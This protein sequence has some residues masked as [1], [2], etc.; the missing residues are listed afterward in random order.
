[1][2]RSV[3]WTIAAAFAALLVL[4][5]LTI[6]MQPPALSG[7][8]DFAMEPATGNSTII[9]LHLIRSDGTTLKGVIAVATGIPAVRIVG[10]GW[11]D[12]AR[13]SLRAA[14]DPSVAASFRPLLLQELRN[15][16]RLE[17]HT[18]LCSFDVYVLNSSGKRHLTPSAG[19][20]SRTYVHERDA[21]LEEA[22][23][24]S[25]ASALEAILGRPVIDE[26]GVTGWYDLEFSWGEDRPASVA[27][28]LQNRFGLLLTPTRREL[29]ALVIDRA[30]PGAAL[31]LLSQVGHLTLGAP[32]TLRNQIGKALTIH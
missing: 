9:D 29:D 4:S 30:E 17:T 23:L 7:W 16:L 12:E 28:V 19:H 10:P 1:M 26:T 27:A 20:D 31:T 21:R 15:R 6:R 22:S 3:A 25:L 8:T 5:T 11:L 18:E 13:Y 14:V 32:Q 2:L 24:P